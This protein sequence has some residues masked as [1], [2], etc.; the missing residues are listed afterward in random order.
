MHD[1][2]TMSGGG[3][4]LGMG[5]WWILILVLVVLGIAA[6]ARYLFGGRG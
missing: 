2:G 3:M 4:W 6:L 1:G 5:I